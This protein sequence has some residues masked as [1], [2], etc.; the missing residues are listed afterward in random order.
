M[1]MIRREQLE[2]FR[3]NALKD[4]E[5][6][7]IEHIANFF[8]KE[9]AKLGELN[10]RE[11]IQY[12]SK[13]A[14]SYGIVSE[15]DVCKYLDLMVV[16]GRAFDADPTL[17]WVARILRDQSVKVPATRIGRLYELALKSRNK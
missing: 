4:F 3:A 11:M 13:R 12:G 7:M 17:P 6:R 15:R 14:S 10:L 2:L 8:P 9:F 5:D 16:F 1:L